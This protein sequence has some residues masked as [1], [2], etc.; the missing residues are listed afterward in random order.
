M[1]LSASTRRTW[2]NLG[3]VIDVELPI[4]EDAVIHAGAALEFASGYVEP[5]SGAGTFA[6]FAL[7]DSAPAAG[8]DGAD[9]VRTV[10]CRVQGGVELDITTDTVA[11]GN[12]GDSSLS[13]EAT[14]DNTFRIETGSAITGTPIGN[15]MRL[16]E[17]GAGGRVGVFF[18][19]PMVA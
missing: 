17:L 13:I 14:D 11:A 18:K 2:L 6:G 15:I 12:L 16:I 10:Q 8:G 3:H 1:A 4:S 5:V 7:A 9:G 19:A